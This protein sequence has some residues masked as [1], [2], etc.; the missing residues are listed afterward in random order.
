MHRYS[1]AWTPASEASEGIRVTT[2]SLA[3]PVV[4]RGDRLAATRH[5]FPAPRISARRFALGREKLYDR[6]DGF[7][8]ATHRIALPARRP[9]LGV[10]L[11]ERAAGGVPRPAKRRRGF[12]R[13]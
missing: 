6:R 1:V 13:R 3:A 12:P 5:V 4:K 11:L 2:M 8:R 10:H 7:A 9:G